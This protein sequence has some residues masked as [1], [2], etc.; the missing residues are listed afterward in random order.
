MLMAVAHL[1]RQEGLLEGGQGGPQRL[2]SPHGPL[3]ALLLLGLQSCA[4]R[5]LQ[6]HGDA[7]LSAAAVHKILWPRT[8][9]DE[10]EQTV[11]FLICARDVY[12]AINEHA[13]I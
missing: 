12:D 3:P 10:E 13:F 9:I 1:L 8:L 11:T 4:T 2:R 5:T 7:L 6:L